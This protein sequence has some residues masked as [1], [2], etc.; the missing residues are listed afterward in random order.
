MTAFL[1]ANEWFLYIALWVAYALILIYMLAKP[2]RQG[3]SA[4]EPVS[5]ECPICGIRSSAIPPTTYVTCAVCASSQ[6]AT[7]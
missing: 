1:T 6:K 2:V 7:K 3:P 4:E 5:T